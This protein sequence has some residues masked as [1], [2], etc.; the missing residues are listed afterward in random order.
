MNESQKA[1]S[2]FSGKFIAIVTTAALTLGGFTT[3]HFYNSF[4]KQAQIGDTTPQTNRPQINEEQKQEVAIYL[5]DDNLQIQPQTITVAKADNPEQLL[6]NALNYL[7]SN[8]LTDT[9]IPTQTQLQ[10]LAIKDDGIHID[11]SADFI[12]GGGSTSMMGRLGQV[13][14]TATSLDEN[15]TIW[16]TVDGEPLEYL[17][18]EGV[19]VRQPMTRNYFAESFSLN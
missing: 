19:I 13:V 18:G 1:N 6:T 7:L 9:V 10:S 5:L 8:E 4:Q 16:I 15:A 12:T 14:Y 2:I 11:L 3:W 17:G